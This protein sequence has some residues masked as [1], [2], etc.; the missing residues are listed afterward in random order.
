MARRAWTRKAAEFLAARYH[1]GDGVFTS[2]G[3][4]TGVFREAG[5][6]LRDTLTGDNGVAFAIGSVAARP[7]PV[8]TMGGGDG[9]RSGADGRQSRAPAR[10][11]LRSGDRRIIVKGAPVIEIYQRHTAPSDLLHP[12][13]DDVKIPFLKAHGAKNDFLLTWMPIVPAGQP[14]A[15]LA[16][17]ICDRHTGIGADGW[18]LV[19]PGGEDADGEIRLFNSDGSVAE[20]SGNGTR[21]AAAFLIHAGLVRA[22]RSHPH[23]RRRQAPAL[24]GA[25]RAALHVRNEH[26]HARDPRSSTSSL[27]LSAGDARRHAGLGG[28]SAMC[29][30]C[31]GLRFRLA[32]DGRGNRIASAFSES[33][34]CVL[35][36]REWTSIRSKCV[37]LNA[38]RVKP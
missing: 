30:A 15:E 19:S 7:V 32:Q 22:G 21:C 35:L 25:Y 2:F 38:E 8:G 1:P 28:Q 24:A 37:F 23:R 13:H 5:I 11:Q 31:G 27:P 12:I 33:H 10:P 36:S 14:L 17:A 20:I 3:D 26:G 16:R 4:Y 29:R 6:P 9:R 34:Q 18:L